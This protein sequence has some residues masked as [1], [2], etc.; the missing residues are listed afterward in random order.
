MLRVIINDGGELYRNL[1]LDEAILRLSNSPTLRIWRNEKSVV[2][3]INS[4]VRDEVNLS[5]ANAS[6][7]KIARRISGGGAVYQDVGNL[8]YSIIVKDILGKG[9]EY[10]YDYLLKG[11]ICSINRLTDERVRV[12]NTS[13]LVVKG[14]KV[15]GNAG[16]LYREKCLLHGTLLLRADLKTL[17]NVLII[18]PKG[19]KREVDPVKFRVKNLEDLLGKRI[20]TEEV[21]KA[22]ISC[23][24]EVLKEEAVIGEISEGEERLS[25]MLKEEKYERKEFIFRI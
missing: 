14:F 5:F 22:F 3:G 21:E 12:A 15:S 13:D 2:L 24:S 7:I 17:Y 18:P 1:A 25:E 4:R 6:G 8:N 19:L 23:F 9:V 11:T 10:L 16:Y 20:E